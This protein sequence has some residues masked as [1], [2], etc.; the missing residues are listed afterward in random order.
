M[1]AAQPR[2]FSLTLLWRFWTAH[3]TKIIVLSLQPW[4]MLH[5]DLM[6]LFLPALRTFLYSVSYICMSKNNSPNFL[7]GEHY[8]KNW[9]GEGESIHSVWR[10]LPP[11]AALGCLV[12][13]GRNPPHQCPNPFHLLLVNATSSLPWETPS[14]VRFWGFP[15]GPLSILIRLPVC[16][17]W[18]HLPFVLS[19]SCCSFSFALSQ[20]GLCLSSHMFSCPLPWNSHPLVLMISW[21]SMSSV[22]PSPFPMSW[23]YL[24]QNPVVLHLVLQI[25]FIKTAPFVLIVY[26]PRASKIHRHF[27]KVFRHH[28]SY[29]PATRFSCLSFSSVS[30]S[31]LPLFSLL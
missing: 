21:K 19:F 6:F 8:E 25:A 26:F 15:P 16:L 22:N 14:S 13:S 23:S 18:M 1:K 9:Q 28:F 10:L 17:S 12:H 30:L 5:E 20:W 7:H 31:L 11:R 3:L 2:A 4:V 24:H 27:S 29:I